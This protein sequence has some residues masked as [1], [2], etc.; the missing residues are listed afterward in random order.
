MEFR[1]ILVTGGMIVGCGGVDGLL[2]PGGIGGAVLIIGGGRRLKNGLE[3]F[4]S[5]GISGG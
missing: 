1:G 2:N 5:V 4:S 3:G